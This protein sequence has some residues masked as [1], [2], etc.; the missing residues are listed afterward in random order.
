MTKHLEVQIW[1]DIACPWC[2]IGK[3]RFEAAL[4]EFPHKDEVDILWHAFE[5]D[6][7]AAKQTEVPFLERLAK[8]YGMPLATAEQR[9]RDI[10]KLA[11]AEGLNFRF[12]IIQH[13]NTFDA[14]R[15]NHLALQQGKQDAV[16]E[17]LMSAY[18]EQGVPI[19]DRSAIAKVAA[20]AGLDPDAVAGVLESDAYEAEV[21]ADEREAA[22]L[23][24][25]GV[26]FFII[27]R[28]AIS[29]AQPKEVFTRA[30]GLAWGE[31]APVALADAPVCGPDGCPI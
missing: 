6:P 13:G 31:H 3:R 5:L 18:L 28:Y 16:N 11:A 9:T 2:F 29:G 21:R 15:L 4:A 7:S 8:K 30:L 27:G 24:I 20:L 17:A 12:D 14:H 25:S 1:S 23:G 19:G 22:K 10:T 26:P